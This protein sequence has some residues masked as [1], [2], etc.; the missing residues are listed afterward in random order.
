MDKIHW[1]GTPSCINPENGDAE[2]SLSVTFTDGRNSAEK[3]THRKTETLGMV[4]TLLSSV[5]FLVSLYVGL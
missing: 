3:Y 4:C 5:W 1:D 2:C